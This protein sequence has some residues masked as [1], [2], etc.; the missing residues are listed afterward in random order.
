MEGSE[1]K[2]YANSFQ[3]IARLGLENIG[4][5]LGHLDNP[6]D[7]LRFIHVAGTNGKGSVCAFLSAMLTHAG[8]KTGL[9]I[10]PNM[11]RVNERISIDGAEVTDAE[12]KRLMARVQKA[13]VKT[14]A[15]TGVYP[16]QF[17][18][19]TAMA[20]CY[21]ADQKCDYVLL[22]TGLG[23]QRDA[24]NIVKTKA[25]S[26]ITHIA[27]DH[28]EYLGGTIEE[29]AR[30]KAGIILPGVPVVS[31][32]QEPGAAHVLEQ[33]CREKSCA[34]SYADAVVPA[35]H[36]EI[37]EILESGAFQGAKLSLGG[38][39]QI[40]NA[41]CAIAAAQALG[42]HADAIRYGLTHAQNMGR[43]ER[44]SARVYFDGAHNPDGVSAL[45]RNL[46]RYFPGAEKTYIMAT[47]RDK[48]IRPSL[49][50]LHDGMACFQMVSVRD[51]A[52]SMPA[53]QLA[54]IALEEGLQARAYP[55]LHE[56]Y[57]DALASG[58]LVILCG[59]LYLYKDFW[60][61]QRAAA[62]EK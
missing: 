44:I 24:T 4:C 37:Y 17:E 56:A 33:V 52:R 59:S 13:C 16:T 39:N 58:K 35:G 3:A 36:D 62:Q 49:R 5:L 55:T 6:Q 21:F 48:D 31:A 14:Q 9:Y 42:L 57:D 53:E 15:D 40:D 54:Q 60:E 25:L 45:K 32:L 22:E 12:M 7:T 11:L 23:G 20:I 2:G 43:F 34:L 47:M 29:I 1:F 50:M 10:S 19:W 38:V 61:M 30:A 28:M 41:A 27:L 46:D 26:V 8:Y 18:I 51:N